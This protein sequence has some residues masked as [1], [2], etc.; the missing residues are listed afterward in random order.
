M[1]DVVTS[2]KKII[3]ALTSGITYVG[4]ENI[5]SNTGEYVPTHEKMAI[6]SAN[7]FKTGQILFPKLRPYLNKVYLAEFNG[8][9]STEFHVFEAKKLFLT[10]FLAIYLRSNIV[11]NQ[12]KHLMTGNT[13][14]RLQTEDINNL[15][16]PHI[17]LD[18]Q[19][20]I[21][22][23][24]N[25]AYQQKQAKEKGAKELLESIDSYL[26]GE[27][28]ITLPEE[29]NSLENRIFTTDFNSLSGG[30]FDSVAQLYVAHSES[31]VYP[32]KLLKSIAE[33]KKG[34][35]IT[36]EQVI[37]GNYPV[38]AGG[39]ISPYTH[40][41]FNFSGNVVTISASGAYAGFVW[42]HDSPIFASDCNVV[43]S[44]NELDI[45]TLY[46]YEVLKLR[47]N[48]IYK[49]QQGSGQ[50]HV[51]G[52]D[53]ANILIPIPP[54]AKQQEIATHIKD[55]RNKAR[56]LQQEAFAILTQA[57]RSVEKMILGENL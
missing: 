43:Y 32:N 14:P 57:K 47:Q 39:Q 8:I 54:L 48:E 2:N 36:K 42:F 12:T 22:D 18:K 35:S 24:M 19:K 51:Y 46:I 1:K 31:C 21:V 53:L 20:Q 6:S 44:K 5:I 30:R 41:K 7:E 55:I 37:V 40:N 34:N 10:H 11:V 3:T 16:I 52:S 15:Y 28:G 56:K 45:I 33:I 25:N 4:L 50:P 23:I 29:D 27:L 49:L 38:I 13:L 26:L 9:C 17:D